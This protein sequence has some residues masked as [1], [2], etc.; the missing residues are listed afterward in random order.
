MIIQEITD[1]LQTSLLSLNAVSCQEQ[2]YTEKWGTKL[3]AEVREQLNADLLGWLDQQ[4]FN[5][6]I[7]FVSS[8]EVR[9][10]Q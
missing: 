1:R 8:T 10:K 4:E 9:V 3:P 7:E 5:A 6:E 2:G